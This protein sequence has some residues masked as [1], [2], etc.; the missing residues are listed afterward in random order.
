M[1]PVPGDLLLVG[2]IA[3]A[4][5]VRGGEQAEAADAVAD[6]AEL[7]RGE[8]GV[9]VGVVREEVLDVPRSFFGE[10]ALDDVLLVHC[11]LYVGGEPGEDVADLC[12]VVAAQAESKDGFEVELR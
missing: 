7:S 3:H 5:V 8:V 9:P 11:L 1:A 2:E 6:G 4:G 10:V 12:T